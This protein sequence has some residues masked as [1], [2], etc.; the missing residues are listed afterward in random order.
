MP[1]LLAPTAPDA[2]WTVVALC[3]RWCRVCEQFQADFAAAACTARARA[4]V[5]LDVEDDADWV[6]AFDIETFPTLLVLHAAR[7]VFFGPVPPQWPVVARTLDA[8]C[9]AHS[10]VAPTQA[11]T[12][13]AAALAALAARIVALRRANRSEDRS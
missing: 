6:D 1:E 8:L 5:W 3:A 13:D 12:A 7:P 4:Y 11:G 9:E 10:D 2:A